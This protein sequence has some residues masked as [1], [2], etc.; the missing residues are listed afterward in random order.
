MVFGDLV[1]ALR[2]E[3]GLT[4]SQL[5]DM[6]ARTPG[7]VSRIEVHGDIPSPEL[8]C[9]LASVLRVPPEKLLQAA[10]QQSLQ[11]TEK[12]LERKYEKA[13]TLFRKSK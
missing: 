2:L 4:V 13:L 10:K 11:T 7:Y 9:V 5:A 1:K 3:R 8:I 6:I 12:K